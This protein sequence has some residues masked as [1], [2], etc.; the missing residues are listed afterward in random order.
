MAAKSLGSPAARRHVRTLL[1]L[2]EVARVT[3]AVL[4]DALD[5]DLP[6]YEDAVLHEAARH[7]GAEAI[8][9][10]DPRGFAKAGSVVPTRR[11]QA[12]VSAA[13]GQRSINR[14]SA[15]RL[16]ADLPHVQEQRQAK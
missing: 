3:R 9:T 1:G 11:L 14:P 4:T 16:A 12:R 8:V 6:D 10:P 5:L 13:T 15:D 2:F 7:A